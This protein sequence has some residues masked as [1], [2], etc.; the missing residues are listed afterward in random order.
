MKASTILD[1]RKDPRFVI[2]VP[3]VLFLATS[4]VYYLMLRARELSPEA[5]TSRLLLFALWNI[6]VI[7]IIGILFVLTR[8]VIKLILE[9]QRGVAGSRFRTKLVLTYLATALVPIGL[10]FF[11]ATDLL[12]V[13]IDR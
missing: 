13:S 7:L 2:T 11:V 5:L 4:L 8:N 9:R 1:Y 12:R 6:N 10:L 3:L